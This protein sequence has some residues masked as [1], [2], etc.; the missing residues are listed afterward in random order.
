MTLWQEYKINHPDGYQYS[1]FCDLYRDWRNQLDV[2]MRQNHI[3][4]DKLFIDYAGQT[5][6]VVNQY[7]GEVRQAQVFIAT[8]GASSYTYAEATLTQSLPDWIGSHVR[9]FEYF[10]GVPNALVPDN[11]K[12]GVKSPHRYEP[13]IN[14]TYQDLAEHYSVAVVPARVREPKDKSKVESAVQVVE[15][16]ILAKLRDRTF[17]SVGELNEAMSVLLE[18]LNSQ[19]FQ[20]L[21]G[22]RRSLFEALGK[23]CT[24]A[25]AHTTLSVCGMERGAVCT[26]TT[27]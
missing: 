6:P 5:V 1:W 27:M 25:F 10:G 4:G 12:S 16:W 11:L 13:V 21:D 2:V 24:Q 17:F 19:S 22:S 23:A 18:E 9:A 8:L 14:P 3:A 15:R 26:L 7:T 20:K